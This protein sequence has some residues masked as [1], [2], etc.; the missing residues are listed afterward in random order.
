MPGG[1]P[2]QSELGW[3]RGLDGEGFR[4]RHRPN[5]LLAGLLVLGGLAVLMIV[6]ALLLR[7]SNPAAVTGQDANQVVSNQ[8]NDGTGRQSRDGTQIVAGDAF[9]SAGR[10]AS[11]GCRERQAALN[12]PSAVQAYYSNLV[13]CLNEAWAAKVRAAQHTFT[14][15]DVVFWRG[16]LQSPCATGS[17]VAFYCGAN[18]TLYFRYDDAT[19]LWNRSAGRSGREFVRMQATGTAA[20]LFGHHVQQLAGIL[21]AAQRLEYDAPNADARLG[22]GRRTELQ[23]SCLGAAFIGANRLPYGIT[24]HLLTIYRRYVV[25]GGAVLDQGSRATRLYWA[26]RGLNSTDVASCNTFKASTNK[27]S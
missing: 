4:D 17:V 16:Y 24:G 27:V 12:K 5:G 22:L 8:L 3:G 21:A 25:A 20:H 26:Q 9:Y 18:R 10:L 15:P 23:A 1:G 2:R 6:A 7:E 14:P 19:K 13:A 11:V